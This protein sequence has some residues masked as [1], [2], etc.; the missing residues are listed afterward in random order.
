MGQH[1]DHIGHANG[2]VA[3]AA[4]NNKLFA[5]TSDNR[6]SWR[7]PVAE[8]SLRLSVSLKMIMVLCD[9]ASEL[10]FEVGG[11]ADRP[12]WCPVLLGSWVVDGSAARLPVR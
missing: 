1:W 5:A 12:A 10:I 3:M 2:V 4:I 11:R 9:L 6:L 7:D 8:T